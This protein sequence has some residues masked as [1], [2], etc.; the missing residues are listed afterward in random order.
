MLNPKCCLFC[1]ENQGSQPTKTK[2]ENK[3]HSSCYR[4]AIRGYFQ[5]PLFV[6]WFFTCKN[7]DPFF[8]EKAAEGA[9]IC[10]S[11]KN[12]KFSRNHL[13]KVYFLGLLLVPPSS[14]RAHSSRFKQLKD[15][16][17]TPGEEPFFSTKQTHSFLT[18]STFL[19][20]SFSV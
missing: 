9:D 12:V 14:N 20:S 8:Q 7:S 3:P 16:Q 2:H 15:V 10:C 6:C 4:F 13:L 11:V 17:N 5:G 1:K 18:N 19:F